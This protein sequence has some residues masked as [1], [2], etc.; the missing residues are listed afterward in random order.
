[1]VPNGI[2]PTTYIPTS[3][4]MAAMREH[5]RWDDRDPVFL[6]PVRVT[7]RKNL[8][9]GI[10]VIAA[11]K[12]MGATPLLVV[13]G[14]LGPHNVRSGEY[15]D[16]LLSRRE[17]RG[18]RDEVAFLALEGSPTGGVEVSDAL[19]T[20]LYW[21]A[22]ALL[23]PSSQEGFGLPLLEAGLAR[24]PIFC[25]DIPVLR[26]VGGPN[27][28]YFEPDGDP[29]AIA[30]TILHELSNLKIAGHRRKVLSTY[31]WDSIFTSSFM[32]LLDK[33]LASEL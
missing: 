7:R 33:I 17:E 11:M 26:E 31:N 30:E 27:A 3:P 13:T 15:L 14:P 16:E 24:L 20:E 22:D 18:V 12:D 4:E 25:T 6:A 9:R 29:D 8:E 10:D 21:W 2:D 28:T 32:P 19:M 1:L 5:L 23:M